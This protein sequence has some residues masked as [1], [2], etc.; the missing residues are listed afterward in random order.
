MSLRTGTSNCSAAW[1]SPSAACWGVSNPFCFGSGA[2]CKESPRKQK[3]GSTEAN[4]AILNECVIDN[5]DL[6]SL[7]SLITYLPS[8]SAAAAVPATASRAATPRCTAPG[9]SH[10][11]GTPVVAGLS[12]ASVHPTRSATECIVTPRTGSFGNLSIADAV[13]AA[14]RTIG[15]SSPAAT[16]T[17]SSSSPA[18]DRTMGS[19][20]SAT[21]TIGRA[22]VFVCRRFIR[23]GS[24]PAML[25]IV[26]PIVVRVTN[27]VIDVRSVVIVYV[28]VV[29]INV[30]VI[31]APAAIVTPASPMTAPGGSYGNSHT[32]RNG[33]PRRVGA[34][35]WIVN[36]RIRV[37]RRSI[38]HGRIVGGDVNHVWTSLLNHDNVL[39]FDL[40]S[41]HFLLLAGF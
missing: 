26:L 15:S 28:L 27:L 23:V 4:K 24:A 21:R 41:F 37:D 30:D 25:W 19:P 18:A 16:R 22:A 36:R 17:I 3:M 12:G 29:D 7:L 6:I 11:M 20:S 5:F 32:K 38:D 10:A 39:A 33:R 31:V 34:D 2:A 40:L 1:I 13:A 14:T 8:A 35:R 9:S